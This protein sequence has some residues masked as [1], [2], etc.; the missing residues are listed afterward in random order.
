MSLAHAF[1]CKP[2][3][4]IMMIRKAIGVGLAVALFSS[5]LAGAAPGGAHASPMQPTLAETDALVAALRFR[6]DMV[7]DPTPAIAAHAVD[8]GRASL[9][10]IDRQMA[11]A[12]TNTSAGWRF[13]LGA[14]VFTSAGAAPG[15]TLVVF[16][17][18]WVDSA[19]FTEW[20]T[21]GADRRIADAAWI[22]GDLVRTAR[23]EIN[24]QPL[25]L[26]GT[27]YRPETLSQS[28]VT[29]VRAIESRFGDPASI[30]TWRQSLGVQDAATFDRLIAPMMALTLQE[31]L[32]RIKA[33]A[34]PAA[35]DD[36]KLTPL[37]AATVQL[38]RTIS[39]TGFAQPLA[40]AT[41]TTPTMLRVLSAITPRTMVGLAP[42]AFVA[43]DRNVTVFFA[44]TATA[45]YALSA[46]FV[47][48][49][50]AYR[51]EQLEF[52]PYAAVY[53]AAVASAGR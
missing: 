16:Y 9:S 28:V 13:L 15:T 7:T 12:G 14:S 38:I 3:G 18:P 49:G 8:P 42:V 27:G 52:I 19:L 50:A 20:R 25:W 4:V 23:A 29:T 37:R 26:R 11:A 22:P 48:Q 1:A 35:G 31:S 10:A 24:P 45:D 33:L 46:R 2:N 5:V 30:G 32:L 43:G 47:D 51:L 53:R 41:Q 21:V 6:G 44:S 17:N 36:P 34:A 39:T 40:E